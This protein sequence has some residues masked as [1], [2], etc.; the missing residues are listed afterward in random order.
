MHRVLLCTVMPCILLGFTRSLQLKLYEQSLC[1]QFRKDPRTGEIVGCFG[2]FDGW[3]RQTLPCWHGFL[4][5]QKLIRNPVPTLAGHGGPNAADFVR[6]NLFEGLVKNPKFGT[7]VKTAFGEN[8]HKCASLIS[9][10]WSAVGAL[11]TQMLHDNIQIYTLFLCLFLHKVWV[12]HEGPTPSEQ[13]LQLV[14]TTLTL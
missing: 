12:P 4:P 2:I 14:F 10:S 1:M 13:H 8:L 5:A 6:Q 3:N 11:Q 7:D 9:I